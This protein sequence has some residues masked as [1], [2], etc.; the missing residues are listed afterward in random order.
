MRAR[1][2]AC[3]RS[4]AGCA[5]RARRDGL[6]RPGRWRAVGDLA[7][8]LPG[9]RVGDDADVPDPGHPLPADEGHRTDPWRRAPHVERFDERRRRA[10]RRSGPDACAG[11]FTRARRPASRQEPID[12][13]PSISASL[14]AYVARR[15]PNPS[16]STRWA[17]S[18]WSQKSGSTIIGLPKWKASVVVLL[19]PW[20]M[21]RSTSGM[22][23]GLGQEL[24][25]PHVGGQLDTRRAA[26][27]W[28]R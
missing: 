14:N 13:R 11:R 27:P 2:P 23:R 24:R 22:M 18:Y 12:A 5:A 4:Q 15:T 16:S 21:T 25:A 26:A 20:V 8:R 3:G 1:S 10:A 9:G 17:L 19:P 6:G 7:H 28:T